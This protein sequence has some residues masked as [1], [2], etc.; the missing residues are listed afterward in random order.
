MTEEPRS[1]TLQR[2]T[3]PPH[4]EAAVLTALEKLP[5]DRFATAAEF[6]EALADSGY[7]SKA[8]VLMPAHGAGRRSPLLLVGWGIA[9]I[10]VIAAFWGGSAPS[11]HRRSPA[12]ASPSRRARLR[13]G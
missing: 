10:A 13:Q 4:V 8:T 9:A 6:A 3:I 5:A 7:T 1:L 11:R 2:K 12:S